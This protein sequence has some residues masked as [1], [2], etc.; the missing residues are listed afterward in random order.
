M[1]RIFRVALSVIG[2]FSLLGCSL[3]AQHSQ[4]PFRLPH[5][6][7][8]AVDKAEQHDFSLV[9]Y[10]TPLFVLT[11]YEKLRHEH[12]PQIHIYIEGDGNAWERSKLSDNPTPRQPL[13][14]HLALQD[15]HP[16]VIYIA[17]PCQYTPPALNNH[18]TPQYWSSH[19]YAPQVIHATSQALDAIKAKTG[20]T[21]FLLVGFSG[22]ASVAAL[23]ASERSDILGLIT[24]AGDLN[25]Q[26]LNTYHHVTPLSGSLNPFHVTEKLRDLP[27]DHWVGGKDKL[28]PSHITEQ[29]VQKIH[30]SRCARVHILKKASHHKEWEK[31]WYA[32]LSEFFNKSATICVN[33]PIKDPAK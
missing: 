3:N 19:R 30:N 25:H 23:V 21:Q 6:T 22:G 27:Q 8:A 24:V 32:I 18:C 5:S 28:I 17:R 14:R 16:N 7:Q 4:E 9:R 15:P 1:Q 31:A 10:Q 29:F 11:T 26:Q 2:L 20:A 13:A 33:T 12:T